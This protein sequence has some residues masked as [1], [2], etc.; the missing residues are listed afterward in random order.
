MNNTPEGMVERVARAIIDANE[1]RERSAT[2]G[3][4]IVAQAAMEECAKIADAAAERYRLSWYEA[5]NVAAKDRCAARYR[6]AQDIAASI[7]QGHFDD[8]AR[9][10]ERSRAKGGE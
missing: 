9:V 8:A 4:E 1:R 7:R 3:M 6:A 2:H 5:K 10:S